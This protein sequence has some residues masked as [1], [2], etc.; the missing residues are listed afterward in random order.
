[1]LRAQLGS[2][3]F[4]FELR[5]DSGLDVRRIDVLNWLMEIQPHTCFAVLELFVSAGVLDVI[6]LAE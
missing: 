3:P 1:M 5:C 2:A 4:R 6:Y